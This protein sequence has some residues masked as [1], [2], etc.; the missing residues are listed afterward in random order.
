[1]ELLSKLEAFRQEAYLY[2]GRAKD[3]TFE[4]MD[5]IMLTRKADSERRFIIMSRISS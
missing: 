2:L 5:A 4:L 3:A 1:M